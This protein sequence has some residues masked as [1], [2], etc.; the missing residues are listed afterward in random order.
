MGFTAMFPDYNA[1]IDHLK[2]SMK[3]K[4][5]DAQFSRYKRES[6]QLKPDNGL[7]RPNDHPIAK[8]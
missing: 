4:E 6:I 3:G 1:R 2:S 7:K 5:L 8:L